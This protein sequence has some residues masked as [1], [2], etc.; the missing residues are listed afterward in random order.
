[1]EFVTKINKKTRELLREQK[2]ITGKDMK[3]IVEQSIELFSLVNDDT[4]LMD[5]IRK[6][7]GIE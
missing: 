6:H 2:K 3:L 4:E 5:I 7:K 1:M